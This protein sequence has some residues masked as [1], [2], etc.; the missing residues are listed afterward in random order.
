MQS[1]LQRNRVLLLHLSFWCVYISFFFYQVSSYQRGPEFDWRHVF[2]IVSIQLTFALL[3]AYLN[4][5]YF[6]PRF[7]AMKN[8]WRYLLEFSVPF[9]IIMFARLHLQ[10]YL[11]DGYTHREEHL[12]EV[13]F[14]VQVITI[15]LFIVIFVGMIRFAVDWFEFEAKKKAV[16]NEKLTAELNFSRR[17]RADWNSD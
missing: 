4:Y 1:L 7:L 17:W 13:R 6:L 3:I 9:A 8:V 5:F 16:E 11:L 15:N 14:I 2:T 10:R 12:Y